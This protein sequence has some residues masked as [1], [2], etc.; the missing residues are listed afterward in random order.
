MGTSPKAVL[1]TIVMS[2]R[3]SSGLG[4]KRL[5]FALSRIAKIRCPRLLPKKNKG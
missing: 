5:I 4:P 2:D 1:V 3:L